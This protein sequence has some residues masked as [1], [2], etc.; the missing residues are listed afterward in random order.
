MQKKNRKS[1]EWTCFFKGSIV[2]IFVIIFFNYLI[3]RYVIL[4]LPVNAQNEFIDII[5]KTMFIIVIMGL[6]LNFFIFQNYYMAISRIVETLDENVDYDDANDYYTTKASGGYIVQSFNQFYQEYYTYK[7]KVESQK[8]VLFDFLLNRLLEGR[9]QNEASYYQMLKDYNFDI[10]NNEFILVLFD[11]FFKENKIADKKLENIYSYIKVNFSS[12][13]KRIYQ[14]YGI[15]IDG[16]M[17]FFILSDI[18]SLDTKKSAIEIER[19]V[20][21]MR[22]NIEIEFNCDLWASVSNVNRGIPGCKIAYFQTIEALEKGH[23]T[24]SENHVLFYFDNI[25]NRPYKRNEQ[26]WFKYEHRFINAINAKNYEEAFNIFNELLK[27][28]YI[29]NAYSLNLARFR[30]FGLL[31]SM[32]NALSEVSFSMNIEFLDQLEIQSALLNCTSLP[33]LETVSQKIFKEI[34]THSANV[35][36]SISSNKMQR[37]AEY[38]QANYKDPDLNAAEVASTF[39]M[40]ASYLSRS[41]KKDMGMSFSDYVSRLRIQHACV[42]LKETEDT[43]LE[44]AE[45]AGFNNT[46]TLNRT[47]KKIEG[48]TPGVYRQDNY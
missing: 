13:M 23:L 9:I 18:E 2:W 41:F 3:Y 16:R 28:D 39:N 34:H 11:V 47:F 8:D 22:G 35:Q 1:S 21:L 7:S 15:E 20:K 36:I 25:I 10:H 5:L 30:L 4:L 12:Y 45:K 32:I 17:A 29:K 38:L 26:L 6:F 33:E 27:N 19:M 43:I 31:N 44:I 14:S 46:L 42:L 24:G 40:N 37:I 48:K